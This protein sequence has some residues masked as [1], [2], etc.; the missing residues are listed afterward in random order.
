MFQNIK[1]PFDNSLLKIHLDIMELS[2]LKFLES[3]IYL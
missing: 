2:V 3:V 1:A